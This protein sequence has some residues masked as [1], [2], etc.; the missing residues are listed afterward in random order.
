MQSVLKGQDVK[1]IE[2][3]LTAMKATG[4]EGLAEEEKAVQKRVAELKKG[5]KDAVQFRKKGQEL[6][7]SEDFDGAVENF[8]KAIAL[9][10]PPEQVPSLLL[11]CAAYEG[12]KM[13]SKVMVDASRILSVDSKSDKGRIWLAKALANLGQ[14]DAAQ[15]EL[16]VILAEQPTHALALEAQEYVEAVNLAQAADAPTAV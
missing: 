2:A 1:A 6:A 14:G 8:S 4:C 5:K 3:T 12:L 16:E 9:E 10:A 7:K 15:A 13:W 11:R